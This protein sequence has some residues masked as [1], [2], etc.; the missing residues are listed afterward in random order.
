MKYKGPIDCIKKLVGALTL[1][2]YCQLTPRSS[3]TMEP[4][5]SITA[6]A[7]HFCSAHSSSFGGA[8]T[9]SS[10]AFSRNIPPSLPPPSISGPAALAHRCSGSQAT[11][12]TSSSSV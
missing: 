6:F 7:P 10:P 12:P 4:A 8:H 1:R 5:A 2:V 3:K 9:M 11:P